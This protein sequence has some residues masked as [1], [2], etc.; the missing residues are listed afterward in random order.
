MVRIGFK[1]ASRLHEDFESEDV[2]DTRINRRIRARQAKEALRTRSPKPVPLLDQVL[3]TTAE[4]KAFERKYP[5]TKG[6]TPQIVKA[7]GKSI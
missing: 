2:N 4:E 5:F 6:D 3:L 7:P 1:K